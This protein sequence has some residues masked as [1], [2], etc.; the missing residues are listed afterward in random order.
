VTWVT[1]W[2]GLRGELL[3]EQGAFQGIVLEA[4]DAPELSISTEKNGVKPL[5]GL[6]LK[7]TDISVSELVVSVAA[8]RLRRRW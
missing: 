7:E 5:A 3:D 6:S 2:G 4:R 8:G 1:T